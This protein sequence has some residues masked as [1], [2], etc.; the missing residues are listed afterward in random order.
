MHP[1][2]DSQSMYSQIPTDTISFS[3]STN[4]EIDLKPHRIHEYTCDIT[5]MR[6]FTCVLYYASNI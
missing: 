4:S 3:K 1:I 2:L 6:R 5:A